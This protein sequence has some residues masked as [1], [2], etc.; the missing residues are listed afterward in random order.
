[1][2]RPKHKL[3]RDR[4][5]NMSLT[6]RE[7]ELL[8]TRAAACRMRPVDYGRARLFTDKRVGDAPTASRPHLDPLF[9]AHLSRLGN[10]LNQVARK[11]NAFGQP[12]PPDFDELLRD[13]RSLI[14]RCSVG[15]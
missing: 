6:A 8:H 12:V 10:N 11:M 2:A 1:L 15:P 9:Y 3:K 5:F 7:H 14:S 4:Q 13:I